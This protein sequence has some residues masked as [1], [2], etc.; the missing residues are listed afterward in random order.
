[1]KKEAYEWAHVSH[2]PCVKDDAAVFVGTNQHGVLDVVPQQPRVVQRVFGLLHLGVH[3]A[4]LNLVLQ[5]LEQFVQRLSCCVLEPRDQ[6]VTKGYKRLKV[7]SHNFRRL[8]TKNKESEG[9][10][11]IFSPF[12]IQWFCH[13]SSQTGLKWKSEELSEDWRRRR[14]KEGFL[15]RF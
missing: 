9:I 1:M 7:T 2:C 3:R 14:K 4:L 15:C 5:G 10:T 6:R 12:T 8:I 13:S 11:L